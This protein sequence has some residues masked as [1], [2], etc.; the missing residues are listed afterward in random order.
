MAR[1]AGCQVIYL[2]NRGLGV[3]VGYGCAMIAEPGGS[4]GSFS[5]RFAGLDVRYI[6]KNDYICQILDVRWILLLTLRLLKDLPST[7]FC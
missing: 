4:T 3:C 5:L 6:R 2:T 1:K 7:T